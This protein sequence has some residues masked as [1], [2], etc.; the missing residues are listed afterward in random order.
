MDKDN[1]KGVS[2]I[3]IL[4]IMIII[5]SVVLSI[6]ILLYSEI[7]VVR[8]I[9]SS[10]AGFYAADSGIEKV[11]Y[12]DRQV[13]PSG[14]GR[15][16]CSMF[17]YCTS[18]TSVD[19]PIYCNNTIPPTIY[20][21]TTNPLYAPLYKN[22]LTGCDANVCDD[23]QIYFETSFNGRTYYTTA[24]IYPSSSIT[25]IFE[26]NSRGAYNGAGRQLQIQ[27]QTEDN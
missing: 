18:N 23:C 20:D 27:I 22:Q 24:R 14:A 16:L 15:G 2:L 3:I 7:K 11:L 12:Y 9:G 6:S 8:N 5:L 17:T 21:D 10:I 25:S 19:S 1:Q 4:F 13:V 26:I